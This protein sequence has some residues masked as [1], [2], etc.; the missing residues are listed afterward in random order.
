[1]G[2][3]EKETGEDRW[4]KGGGGREGEKSRGKRI[5]KAREEEGR[6]GRKGGER[7]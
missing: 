2:L 1:M 5:K 4:I 7:K 6:G 3:R